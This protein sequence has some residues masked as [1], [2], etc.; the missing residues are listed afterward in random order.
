M[1]EYS[2]TAPDGTKYRV[3]GPEGASK[4]E[5]LAQVKAYKKPGRDDDTIAALSN[6][7]QASEASAAK[8]PGALEYLRN[9]AKEG[10]AGFMGSPG[11]LYQMMKPKPEGMRRMANNPRIAMSP[12]HRAMLLKDAAEMEAAPPPD[13]LLDQWLQ[14]P[15]ATS[16]DYGG[17]LEVD[18][19]MKTER[20]WLRYAGGVA[21]MAGAGAPLGLAV[22][23]PAQIYSL[24][25]G[26]VYGGLGGQAARDVGPS[27]GISPEASETIGEVAG[28]TGPALLSQGAGAV[29][30]FAKSRLSP[31]FARQKAEHEA[32]AKVGG[33]V[34]AHADSGANLARAEELRARI[35]GYEPSAAAAT[36]AP[37][38]IALERQLASQTPENLA[39]AASKVRNSAEAIENFVAQKYDGGTFDTPRKIAVLAKKKAADLAQARSNVEEKLTDLN[40]AFD[41]NPSGQNGDLLRKKL[42]ERN[43]ILR[44]QKDQNYAAVEEEARNLGVKEDV[45]DIVD[46][47]KRTLAEDLNG[48]QPENIPSIFREV[49]SEFAKEAKGGRVAKET[50][51]GK[52]I[53]SYEDAAPA[54]T[55]VT[56]D[57][58]MSMRRRVNSDLAEVSASSG[59]DREAKMRL[60]GQMK[61][62]IESKVQQYNDPAKYGRLGELMQKAEGFFK[63]EYAPR[64]KQ[65]FG[66]EANL[67]DSRAGGGMAYTPEEVTTKLLK[68]TDAQAVRD[69]KFLY[70][71]DAEAI[72]ALKGSWL[73]A[74]HKRAGIFDKNGF[75]KPTAIDNFV[76]T[77][78][79]AFRELPQSVQLDI[80]RLSTDSTALLE[81]RAAISAAEKKLADNGFVQLVEGQDPEKVLSVAIQDDKAMRVL[82]GMA[83]KA[84]TLEQNGLARRVAEKI[85][86]A[87]D[88]AAYLNAHSGTVNQVFGRMGPNHMQN[89]EDVVEAISILK[90]ADIPRNVH[91]APA[92]QDPMMA[93]TGSSMRSWI[94]S[95]MSIE[96]GRTGVL[97]EGGFMLGRYLAK[98]TTGH[99]DAVMQAALYDPHFSKVL[100]GALKSKAPLTAGVQ[101]RLAE[102]FGKIG[103]RA[104]SMGS[105]DSE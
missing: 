84:G 55:E 86:E 14:K 15:M 103:V 82:S 98:M 48:F 8:E 99:R 18:H 45:G 29:A 40:A 72:G 73:D 26:T 43:A 34:E 97:Q 11:D 3:T 83:A 58:L 87:P 9:K 49:K 66:F 60:L 75:V 52:K 20:P 62:M 37:G 88:P 16:K 5:V 90:R 4:E 53:Y 2:V 44:G 28:M 10:F 13:T 46:F 101:T 39:T 65:G 57:S 38:L 6:I 74:L 51:T 96:R 42:N 32:L 100:A 31:E 41:R 24:A 76:K 91:G 89:V 102:E 25:S 1:A 92:M 68:P 69:F 17:V 78:Q 95:L 19:E 56:F 27:L 21:K 33:L 104:Y 22:R 94:A 47:T 7:D 36:G 35:P 105:D 63:T 67:R 71:D 79:D 81:R 59:T 54:S 77:H 64:F 93:G 30:K 70:G 12:E 80:R 23:G 61:G 50:P 85:T